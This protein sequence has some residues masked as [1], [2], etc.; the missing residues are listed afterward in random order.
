MGAEP[1]DEVSV[2]FDIDEKQY[3]DVLKND[4]STGGH[5]YAAFNLS[6]G[7]HIVDI[8]FTNK[9]GDVT[10]ETRKLS[11]DSIPADIKVL[12]PQN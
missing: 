7:D 3:G 11:V 12:Y 4:S 5:G 6:D 2:R 9:A 10:V 1:N 8:V